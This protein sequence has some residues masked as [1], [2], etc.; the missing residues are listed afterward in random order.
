M[1]VALLSAA[2][3]VILRLLGSTWRVRREWP[4]RLD[5]LLARGEALIVVFWHEDI[6]P[7]AW[8]H[9]HQ[10]FAPLI[11]THADG[12]IIARIVR[13][14][15]YRTVRGS[16]SRGGARA[17]LEMAR[18]LARGVSVAITPDGP[19]GPRR[20]MTPGP[21]VLA[22]RTGRRVL[23]VRAHADRAWRLATWDRHLI[24]KP[25]ARVT[26]RYSP[27]VTIAA[28]SVQE[29]VEQ[30]PYVASLLDRLDPPSQ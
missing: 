28:R 21:T 13:S 25:F 2:G 11:S 4:E 19:R 9:R 20:S 7:I 6:L 24:P 18:L 12:E 17:L 15:G 14:L 5:D 10:G 30:A 1:Q 22:Q 8:V 23:A 29:A 26:L 3:S 27:A 16:T